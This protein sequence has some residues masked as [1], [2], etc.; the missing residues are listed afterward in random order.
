MFTRVFLYPRLQQWTLVVATCPGGKGNEKEGK[1][2]PPTTQSF[3]QQKIK[4]AI[5]IFESIMI[6]LGCKTLLENFVRYEKLG[7]RLVFSAQKG[8]FLF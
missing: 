7:W 3:S 5:G 6:D 1:S 4:D 8:S 2:H